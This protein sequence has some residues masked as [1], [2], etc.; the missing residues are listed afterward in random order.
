MDAVKA[1]PV[2]VR[3]DIEAR[4]TAASQ[5]IAS[6]PTELKQRAA[7]AAEGA[8]SSLKQRVATRTNE[9]YRTDGTATDGTADGI[10]GQDQE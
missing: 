8:T 9:L 1:V 7:D 5:K 2:N 3:K 6:L 4:A 10:E